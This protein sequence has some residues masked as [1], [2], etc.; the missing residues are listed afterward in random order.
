M[1]RK[2]PVLLPTLML[3]VGGLTSPVA[4]WAEDSADQYWYY[5]ELQ[6]L[7]MELEPEI[8]ANCGGDPMCREMYIPMNK[9][10]EQYSALNRYRDRGLT[11]T[12]ADFNNKTIKIAYDAGVLS[13]GRSTPLSIKDLYVVQFDKGY[14]DGGFADKIEA[15]LEVPH[16]HTLVIERDAYL[17]PYAEM[18][19]STPELSAEEP[20]DEWIYAFFRTSGPGIT[21][22]EA[23][24]FGGCLSSE[25]YQDDTECRVRYNPQDISYAPVKVIVAPQ[26]AMSTNPSTE[27]SSAET[28][29]EP[30]PNTDARAGIGAE[31]ESGAGAETKTKSETETQETT[32][33]DAKASEAISAILT[34]ETGTAGNSNHSASEF[35]W[36]LGAIFGLGF[37]T[38]AWFF[39][40]S[41]KTSKNLQKKP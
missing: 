22:V 9:S 30:E 24:G 5:D 6:A 11:I 37:A 7:S 40:P 25:D 8:A 39:W 16:M 28:G 33:S 41:R 31:A 20:A 32:S 4:V 19:F 35:P 29:L 17:Q 1:G 3:L 2:A 26:V 12:S 38:L 18:E 23:F 36:W 21:W 10:G 34:P 14:T 13:E 27:D 15:G